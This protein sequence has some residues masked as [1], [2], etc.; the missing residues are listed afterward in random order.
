[1]TINEAREAVYERWRAAALLPASQYA[2]DNERFEPPVNPTTGLN[3]PWARVSVRH[4]ASDQETLGALGERRYNRRALLFV[5]LY[6]ALE[7]GAFTLDSLGQQV[8]A[9]FEG[10]TFDTVRFSKGVLVR[11]SLPDETWEIRV[12]EAEFDYEERK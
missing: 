1:M 5:K 4:I 8:R 9:V 6:D 10:T 12:V 11:E 2:F 3:L 7:S